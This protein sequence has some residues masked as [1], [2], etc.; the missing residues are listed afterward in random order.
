MLGPVHLRLYGLCIALGVLAAVWI[1][2]RRWSAWGRRSGDD[3]DD[4]AGG[5]ARR[6]DRCPALP[7]HHRLERALPGV[8]GGTAFEIW[9]G[10]LGIPGGVVLGAI[11]GVLVARHLKCNWRLMA[12]AVAPA[13]PVAQ[14]IGRLGNYFNQELFGRPTTLPWALKVDLLHRPAG[15]EQFATFQPTFLYE[16]LWNLALAGLII[17][18]TRRWVLKTG[19]WF[20]LYVLGYGLGRLWVESLRIDEATHIFGLRVNIWTA[21]IA[22]AGGTLWFFWGGSPLDREA[23]DRLRAGETLASIHGPEMPNLAEADGDETAG[24]RTVDDEADDDDAADDEAD[25]ADDADDDDAA[26]D[27]ADA[28][29]DADDADA[30]AD[31]EADAAAEAVDDEPAE[32]LDAADQP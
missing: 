4:G 19:R 18:A 15:Y 5:G 14:A 8:G 12:D 6:S 7:R 30:A 3:H 10:G 27:E 20:A 24:D 28:A 2:R 21:L 16:A 31:D 26:D 25:A 11:A 1:A 9:K 22:I 13:I 32:P 17:L 29:D 23:T